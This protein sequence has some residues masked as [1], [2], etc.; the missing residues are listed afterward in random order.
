A[1][2]R[3]TSCRSRRAPSRRPSGRTVAWSA[4]GA[5]RAS[6]QA[7][8]RGRGAPLP[9]PPGATLTTETWSDPRV[10]WRRGRDGGRDRAFPPEH[11][12]PTAARKTGRVTLQVAARGINHRVTEGTEEAKRREDGVL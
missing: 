7:T 11:R 9:E 8:G 3:T 4:R 10:W 2:P 6:G 5:F 1:G 12:I